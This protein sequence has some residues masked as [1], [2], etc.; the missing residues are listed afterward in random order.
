LTPFTSD[1]LFGRAL[2][3]TF[4]CLFNKTKLQIHFTEGSSL[5]HKTFEWI[6]Q[7]HCKFK[8]AKNSSKVRRIPKDSLYQKSCYKVINIWSWCRKCNEGWRQFFRRE[9]KGNKS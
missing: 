6:V 1:S 7:Y 8:R 9:M 4:L 5:S 2:H 3:T